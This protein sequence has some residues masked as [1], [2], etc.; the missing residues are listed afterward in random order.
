LLPVLLP[1]LILYPPLYCLYLVGTKAFFGFLSGDAFYYMTLA[2]RSTISFA[3]Y[4]GET[5]TNGFHPLWHYL[6]LLLFKMVG[7]D[8]SNQLHAIFLI[9]CLLVAIGLVMVGLAVRM[10]TGSAGSALWMIPGPF[11]VLF[12]IDAPVPAGTGVTYSYSCWA[13]MNGMESCLSILFGGILLYVV[14]KKHQE[15]DRGDCSPDIEKPPMDWSRGLSLV[16]GL[17][18]MLC[19]MSR[20]DDVFLLFGWLFCLPVLGSTLR[21]RL[22]GLS[23]ILG[24]SAAALVGC[25]LYNYSAELP[26]LP[27]SGLLKSGFSA[28][29]NSLHLVQDMFPPL[30]DISPK[31][32]AADLIKMWMHTAVRSVGMALPVILA[33]FWIREI[34]SNPTSDSRQYLRDSLHYPFLVYVVLKGLYNFV[35]VYSWHQGYWYYS[36]SIIFVNCYLIRSFSQARLGLKHALSGSTRR[37]AS[38]LWVAVYLLTSAGVIHC[39]AAGESW[40]HDLWKARDQ[41]RTDLIKMQPDIRLI[42]RHDG[43]LSFALDLPALPITGLLVDAA[44]Y[45]AIKRGSYMDYCLS[46]GFNTLAGGPGGY[47]RKMDGFRIREIYSHQ[48]TGLVLHRISRKSTGPEAN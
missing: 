22:T 26:L 3:T 48:P 30:L 12:R 19:V 40:S 4:D 32:S 29:T 35:N 21:E 7:H 44:G 47:S 27:V 17:L 43:L 20:L 46:R 5:L 13:F 38:I 28:G 25:A 10:L 37:I 33:A 42:D 14:A 15:L 36:L 8:A 45:D 16:I 1:A 2:S 11:F 9:S 18:I 31:T 34:F 41:I 23:L 39:V 24:P 6:A